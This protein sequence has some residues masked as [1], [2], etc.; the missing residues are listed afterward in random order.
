MKKPRFSKKDWITLGLSELSGKGCDAIKLE[1]IC[2]AA[3]LTRGSFYHHFDD[4]ESFLTGL[5]EHWLKV[6]TEDVAAVIDADDPAKDRSEALTRAA[7]EIDYKLELGIRELGRRLPA[8]RKVI[9]QADTVRLEVVSQ[10]YKARFG[11]DAGAADQFAYLEYAAFSG[12]IL[13]NPDISAKRQRALADLF[14]RTLT[15]ALSGEE[16]K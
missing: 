9:R 14:D 11:L 13:L 6:Q 4:H 3:G 10:L 1:A 12:I 8:V 15:K 2:K 7:M 5:A 16:V